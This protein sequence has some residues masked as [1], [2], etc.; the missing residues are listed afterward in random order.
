MKTGTGI[1]LSSLN[2]TTTSNNNKIEKAL[3]VLP[4][5]LSEGDNPVVTL[6]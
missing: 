3:C 1:S 2:V 5:P 4:G 6:L